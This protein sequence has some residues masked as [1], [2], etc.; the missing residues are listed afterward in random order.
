MRTPGHLRRVCGRGVRQVVIDRP[1]GSLSDVDDMCVT[2]AELHCDFEFIGNH[3]ILLEACTLYP[4]GSSLPV[5]IGDVALFVKQFQFLTC[6]HLFS[7]CVQHGISGSLMQRDKCVYLLDAVRLH[8]TCACPC[9][10]Y[11]FRWVQASCPNVR[12]LTLVPA[13]DW[14]MERAQRNATTNGA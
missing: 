8:G 13:R 3:S 1:A 12:L 9:R 14:S 7:L 2:F 10:Q 4:R 5:E 6:E 11:V